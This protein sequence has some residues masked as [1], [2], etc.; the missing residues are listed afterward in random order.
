MDTLMM[1]YVIGKHKVYVT[2]LT[3]QLI[4]NMEFTHLHIYNTY[5]TNIWF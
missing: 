5:S 2:M 4:H 1:K 3:F